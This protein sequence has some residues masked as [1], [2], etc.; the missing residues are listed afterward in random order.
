MSQGAEVLATVALGSNLGDPA[1]QL[2]RALE[3]LAQ[4]PRTRLVAR[5]RWHE[6]EPVGGPA[7]QP[8]FRNGVVQIET[9]LG[10]RELL[11]ELQRLEREAGRAREKELRH[12]PRVLDLD[13]VFYGD[14]RLCEPGLEVP[15]PRAEE[16]LFVLE[17]LAEIAPELLLSGCR[18]SVRE[19]VRELRSLGAGA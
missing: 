11:V 15:H 17:P 5:S 3:R 7:G 18:K 16:R 14:L 6:T 10:P 2:D 13:L 12:G 1:A 19:R 4:L 9:S 8:R